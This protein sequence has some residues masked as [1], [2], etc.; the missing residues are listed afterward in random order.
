MWVF[1]FINPPNYPQSK[2]IPARKIHTK[3]R[4]PSHLSQNF[5]ISY[6]FPKIHSFGR[7]SPFQWVLKPK[8]NTRK[9][10]IISNLW[11]GC[12]ASNKKSTI[13][14]RSHNPNTFVSLCRQLATKTLFQH[15]GDSFVYLCIY[16]EYTILYYGWFYCV[17]K[18]FLRPV[19]TTVFISFASHTAASGLWRWPGS[20][21]EN[22]ITV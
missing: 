12:L 8:S 10:N 3:L 4:P 11:Y 21:T 9:K 19:T 13:S 16:V 17:H 2:K 22:W 14:F 5:I 6:E 20:H 7:F 15:G 18:H 1:L